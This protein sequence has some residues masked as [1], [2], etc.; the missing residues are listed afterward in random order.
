MRLPPVWGWCGL[1][2]RRNG[3]RAASAELMNGEDDDRHGEAGRLGEDAEGVGIA[4]ALRPFVDRVVAGRGDDDRVGRPRPGL[5][6][7]SVL[8]ADRTAGLG[9]ERGGIYESRARPG[10]R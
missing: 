1:T 5:A 2:L 3:A 4:D 6:G 10:L 9:L 8:A 7:L